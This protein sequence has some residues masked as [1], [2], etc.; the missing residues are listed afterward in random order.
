MDSEG[1][2]VLSSICHVYKN[3]THSCHVAAPVLLCQT[4]RSLPPGAQPFPPD[5]AMVTGMV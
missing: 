5:R 3:H 1:R 4:H 2:R